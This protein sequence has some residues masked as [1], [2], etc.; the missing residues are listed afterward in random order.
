MDSATRQAEDV[1]APAPFFMGDRAVRLC[2]YCC[3]Y[4]KKVQF[5]PAGSDR[6]LF[7]LR[8]DGVDLPLDFRQTPMKRPRSRTEGTH[9]GPVLRKSWISLAR[10]RIAATPAEFICRLLF[11][12]VAN[13]AISKER[14]AVVRWCPVYNTSGKNI[15]SSNLKMKSSETIPFVMMASWRKRS[16]GSDAIC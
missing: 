3:H 5:D 15:S 7:D 11:R 8:D 13:S 12:A 10:R 2:P 6:S 14:Q 4:R 9:T 1:P 16:I